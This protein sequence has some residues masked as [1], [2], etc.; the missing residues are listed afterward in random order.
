MSWRI[1]MN[2]KRLCF[3]FYFV[4]AYVGGN[5]FSRLPIIGDY[6]SQTANWASAEAALLYRDSFNEQKED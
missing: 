6:C 1:R 2:Y 4:I 3:G 5:Y